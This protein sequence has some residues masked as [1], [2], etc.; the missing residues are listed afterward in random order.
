MSRVVDPLHDYRGR[1]D[2]IGSFIT[3]KELPTITHICI[4]K[5][6][7]YKALMMLAEKLQ[8]RANSTTQVLVKRSKKKKTVFVPLWDSKQLRGGNLDDL[9]QQLQTMLG[10]KKYLQLKMKTVASAN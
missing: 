3:I 1:L 7:Q 10:K 2:N 6:V 8:D 5:K 9:A 4:K